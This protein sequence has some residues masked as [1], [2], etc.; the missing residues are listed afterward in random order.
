MT[1]DT[2]REEIAAALADAQAA[3]KRAQTIDNE[4]EVLS[5]GERENLTIPQGRIQSVQNCLPDPRQTEE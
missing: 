3:L 1:T 5:L 4:N 2:P